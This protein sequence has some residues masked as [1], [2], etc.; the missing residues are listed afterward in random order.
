MLVPGCIKHDT[1]RYCLDAPTVLDHE[2]GHRKQLDSLGWF[3]FTTCYA[4]PSAVGNLLHRFGLL[5]VNYFDQPW[6]YKADELGGVTTRK[7]RYHPWA[8]TISD[9]YY[10]RAKV[11][12]TVVS[13]MYPWLGG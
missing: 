11:I 8:E 7:S 2:L 12:S 3:T 10:V 6:E 1:S 9:L 4:I 5:P 13:I